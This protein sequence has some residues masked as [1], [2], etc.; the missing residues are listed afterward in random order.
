MITQANSHHWW[1]L[2][3]DSLFIMI[4]NIY[5]NNNNENIA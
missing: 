2:D 4:N 1:Q 5:K 3:E